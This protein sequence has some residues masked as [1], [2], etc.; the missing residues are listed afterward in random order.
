MSRVVIFVVRI[1][2]LLIVASFFHSLALASVRF[3][4]L[5][6]NVENPSAIA[7]WYVKYVGLDIIAENKQTIFVGDS[8]HHFMFELYSK[9]EVNDS[10][11]GLSH[12]ASHVAFSTDDVEGLAKIMVEGGAKVLKQFTN[13]VGDTVINM[14]DPWGINLQIIHR[15]KPKL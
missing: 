13:S 15:V 9:A 7:A 3:E 14:K 6:V 1:A 5:A 4:H 10:Y 8:D 12:S 11:S 2:I